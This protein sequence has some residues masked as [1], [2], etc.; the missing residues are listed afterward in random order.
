MDWIEKLLGL[1]LDGG[2]GSVEAIITI[3]VVIFLGAL[4]TTVAR[5][6]LGRRAVRRSDG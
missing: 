5:R 4:F 2:N 3:G 1:N 6:T